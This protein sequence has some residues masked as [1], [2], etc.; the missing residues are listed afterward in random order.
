M[1]GYTNVS[2]CVWCEGPSRRCLVDWKVYFVKIQATTTERNA[3]R[4]RPARGTANPAN[5]RGSVTRVVPR[6]KRQP[7]LFSHNVA[8]KKARRVSLLSVESS[9]SHTRF[10]HVWASP[11]RTPIFSKRERVAGWV[12]SRSKKYDSDW[13]W[14]GGRT[15]WSVGGRQEDTKVAA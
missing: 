13:R 7:Q 15:K 8:S 3:S 14:E 9:G 10:V 11:I 1:L 4:A 12:V 6:V 2:S 5:I